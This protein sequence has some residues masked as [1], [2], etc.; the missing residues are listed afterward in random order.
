MLSKEQR[1]YGG[2]NDHPRL[3]GV[4]GPKKGLTEDT[5]PNIIYGCAL[6]CSVMFG[7]LRPH[8]L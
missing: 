1:E 3:L 8:G 5:I 2:G 4:E 7:S 6:S